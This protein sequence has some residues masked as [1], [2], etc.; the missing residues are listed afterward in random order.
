MAEKGEAAHGCSIL[1]HSKPA[2]P[3]STT[4]PGEFRTH[5]CEAKIC[6]AVPSD[7]HLCNITTKLGIL[8]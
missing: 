4:A 2:P 6:Y 5:I 1:S 8:G 7:P 3:I